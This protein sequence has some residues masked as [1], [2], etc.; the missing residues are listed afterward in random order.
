MRKVLTASAGA[1]AV[2]ATIACGL[3]TNPDGDGA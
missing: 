1:L 3:G 2:L